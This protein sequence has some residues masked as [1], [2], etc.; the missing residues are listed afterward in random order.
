MR[1][2]DGGVDLEAIADN[3]G[4]LDQGGATLGVEAG[5]LLGVEGCERFS[6]VGAFVKNGGPRKTGLG[7]LESE[8]FEEVAVVVDGNT[9]FL[10][11]ILDVFGVVEPRRPGATFLFGH[12]WRLY[13]SSVAAAICARHARSLSAQ[14][15]ANLL[16]HDE[17]LYFA[18]AG[19]RQFGHEPDV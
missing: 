17:L 14:F 7:S 9:P 8:H 18:G 19:Q 5:N 10:V 1:V 13:P 15:G 6:V 2:R 3:P 4:V 11:V 12:R 16:A